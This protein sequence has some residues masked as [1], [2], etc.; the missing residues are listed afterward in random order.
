MRIHISDA[1]H[2]RVG[3]LTL[4]EKTREAIRRRVRQKQMAKAWRRPGLACAAACLVIA[5]CAVL[6]LRT[7]LPPDD[8]GYNTCVAVTYTDDSL[9]RWSKRTVIAWKNNGM[10]SYLKVVAHRPRATKEGGSTP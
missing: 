6:W 4:G 7:P 3:H 8:V 9:T 1:L 5:P 10:D 2:R